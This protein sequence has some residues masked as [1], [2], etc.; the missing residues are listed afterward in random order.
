MSGTSLSGWQLKRD[1]LLTWCSQDGRRVTICS[2]H[3]GVAEPTWL[4]SDVS[5]RQAA[6]SWCGSDRERGPSKDRDLRT[7]QEATNSSSNVARRAAWV[8]LPLLSFTHIVRLVT[9]LGAAPTFSMNA[10]SRI[11]GVNKPVS[12]RW[13]NVHQCVLHMLTA[14]TRHY[15]YLVSWIFEESEGHVMF[16]NAHITSQWVCKL[17][18]WRSPLLSH[19]CVGVAPCQIIT[20]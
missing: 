9:V 6:P 14:H 10:S 2:T 15:L 12:K 17:D 4:M 18:C 5:T 16:P 19:G 20:C 3:C 1:K 7:G 11:A 8:L 13:D